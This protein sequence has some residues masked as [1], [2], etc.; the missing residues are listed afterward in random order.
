MFSLHSFPL[1]LKITALIFLGGLI[2]LFLCNL[3]V[4]PEGRFFLVN[5][6]GFNQEKTQAM[7]NGG[8]VVKAL[9]LERG[10]YDAVILGSSRSENGLNPRHPAFRTLQVYNASLEDTNLYEV[11]QVFAFAQKVHRLKAVVIGLDFLLFTDKRSAEGDF[12]YSAFAGTSPWLSNFQYLAS[13]QTLLSSFATVQNN[14]KG[15]KSVYTN[16][17]MRDRTLFL[18]GTQIN[19][20]NLFITTLTRNFLVNEGTYGG[21]SYGYDRLELLRSLVERCRMDG[22]D[23]YLFIPPSHARDL[24]ALRVLGLYPLFEQWKRDLVSILA[25]D[26]ARHPGE[27]PIRLWD[28]TGY[29]TLTTEE[30]PS[31][32]E[33]GKPMQWYWESSHFKKELGDLV[34]DRLF[35]YYEP[36]HNVPEDFGI[37]ITT[38]NIEAHLSRLREQQKRYYETHPQEVAEVEYLAKITKRFRPSR[39]TVTEVLSQE[40]NGT[41][42]RKRSQVGEAV[43]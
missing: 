8:R 40:N 29:T 2:F 27:K 35:N 15:E 30:V 7:D 16:Q 38:E 19:H 39:K 33:K 25:T 18:D 22:T 14:R 12:T 9:A 31:A 42:H 43:P 3:I 37:S 26:A 28:F 20:R 5:L 21:F 32:A 6:P 11:S 34:L 36:G 17:G 4:D 13:F 10:N 24:E 41:D 1:H 23:L